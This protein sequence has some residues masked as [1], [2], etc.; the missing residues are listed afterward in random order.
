MLAMVVGIY[1]AVDFF[2][3]IDDFMEA[4]LPLSKALI[5]F[6]LPDAFYHFPDPS[7][8][9]AACGSGSLWSYDQE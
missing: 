8:L 3:R 6:F 9:Y 4:N 7:G 5:F 1:V 2:E